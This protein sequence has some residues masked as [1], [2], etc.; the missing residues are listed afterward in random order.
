ME[1]RA[2]TEEEKPEEEVGFG[3]CEV[4]HEAC[5]VSAP[6]W[7]FLRESSRHGK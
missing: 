4:G 5:I 1:R 7:I 2:Y 6:C 3:K